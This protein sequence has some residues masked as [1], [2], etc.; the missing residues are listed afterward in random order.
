MATKR[1][2]LKRQ[3]HRRISPAALEAYRAMKVAETDDEWWAHHR[4]LWHELRCKPWQFPCTD[5]SE[6][7]CALEETL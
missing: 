1:T 2:P 7:L 6:L 3:I 4:V 5:D